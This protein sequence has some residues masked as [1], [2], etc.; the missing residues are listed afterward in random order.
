[1]E[2]EER[3]TDWQET[4]LV[5]MD[6]FRD[7]ARILAW[8]DNPTPYHV[9]ISE[10]MLQQTRVEAVKLY[11]DRFLTHL[12]DIQS[13][14]EADEEILLKLWEGL[15]YYSRVRNL[16]KAARV[17]MEAYGGEL[18]ADYELLKT[19]PGIGDYT[20]GAL[21]SIAFGI[22]V[23]AVDGNVLRV[24]SRITESYEDILKQ[25]TKK[26]ITELLLRVM[27]RKNPGI[28][29]QA[30]MELGA[31]VC[32]PNGAPLC[33][34]CPL[35]GTCYARK[36]GVT[37]RIPVKTP[38]KARRIEH[39]YVFVVRVPVRKRLP[40][41]E[42]ASGGVLCRY[43]IRKR[44]EKGL[45]AG[46]WEWPNTEKDGTSNQVGR[47]METAGITD[48]HLIDRKKGKHVFSHIEWHMDGILIETEQIPDYGENDWI[49]VTRDELDELYAL[50]SAFEAFSG[51]IK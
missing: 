20:A 46:L 31:M 23:P 47:A 29:N 4:A 42:E 35:Y 24:I 40:G 2:I 33:D 5:L 43:G 13:L 36:N 21:A 18:P 37:D 8:R 22:P 45:L 41:E 38:K 26:D 28:F 17:V 34:V 27:P 44:S 16:Q 11:Y 9:W 6:W 49:F 50:P 14:A 30:L 48:Y 10:I 32:I 51:W 1:M 15:G 19:L 39:R 7:N 25:K 3:K 12:P